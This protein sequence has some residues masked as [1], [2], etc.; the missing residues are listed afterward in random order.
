MYSILIFAAQYLPHLGGV[1]NYTYNLSKELMN[2]GH[3]VTIVTSNVQDL[4]SCEVMEGITI[5]RMPCL[6]ILKGRF[7]VLKRNSEFKRLH[8]LLMKDSFDFVM[9]NT[10]F[11]FHSVYGVRFAKKKNIPS[12]V[13]DHGTSHLTVHNPLL[14]LM[15]NGFEHIITKI[16]QMYNTD[17]YGVSKASN[18]W[19]KH[20]HIEAKGVLYNAIDAN[21]IL[22]IYDSCKPDF[23][24]RFH[25]PEDAVT[26]SYTGRV[27]KEKG[28]IQLIE[29]VKQ[30]HQEG[31]KVYLFIAGDGD[32]FDYCQQEKS[33]FI[34][35]LGRLSFENIICLLKFT[36]IFCLPS[37]SEGFST[38]LLEAA[39]CRNYIVTTRRGGAPE[40]IENDNY[41]TIIDNNRVED[42]YP[43][44]LEAVTSIPRRN[45]GVEL[46]YQKVISNFTW[47]LTADHVL[48]IVD[49][50]NKR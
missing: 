23:A 28:I 7:P 6:K 1:E 11:Y 42:V 45:R 43:A 47:N 44:L 2:R 12:I 4:E 40:L 25:I 48:D 10:R 13:I 39:V 36:D 15:G 41:G 3:K 19:L 24:S 20:F 50:K 29:S 38:S 22:E 27:L 5:Y 46:T 32:L 26:I 35:P 33:D 34:I 9:V 8:S 37:D 16:V 49:Y 14:D 21:R 30:L 17:F 31:Y 18:Q